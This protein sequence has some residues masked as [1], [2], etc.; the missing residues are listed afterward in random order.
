MFVLKN[1]FIRGHWVGF[2]HTFRRNPGLLHL[3]AWISRYKHTCTQI[4]ARIFPQ[5]NVY[6]Q[7][8]L[9]NEQKIFLGAE[10][11]GIIIQ[12]GKIGN[13]AHLRPS[14]SRW[15]AQ[16]QV[17]GT[18]IEHMKHRVTTREKKA[19]KLRNLYLYTLYLCNHHTDSW[20]ARQIRNFPPI[21]LRGPCC[22]R[23]RTVGASAVCY[24]HHAGN[25]A[26]ASRAVLQYERCLAKNDAFLCMSRKISCF[27]LR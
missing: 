17:I 12:R 7:N 13:G 20:I 15:R 22:S 9:W 8:V 23:C 19:H 24:A 4:K 25:I 6:L 18:H 21:L 2:F 10:T 27:S 1:D 5:K 26:P 3:L 11:W 14:L 16:T